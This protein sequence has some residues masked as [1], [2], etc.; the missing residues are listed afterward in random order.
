[1]EG[2]AAAEAAFLVEGAFLALF[3][4]VGLGCACLPFAG[5]LLSALMRNPAP[6]VG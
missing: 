3:F 5:E 4:P 2:A 1:V 6:W